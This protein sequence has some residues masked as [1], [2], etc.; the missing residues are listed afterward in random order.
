MVANA[1]DKTDLPSAVLGMTLSDITGI[2]QYQFVRCFPALQLDSDKVQIWLL[3][4]YTP[5][6]A[7]GAFHAVI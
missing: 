7:D 6:G 2:V 4:H 1:L 5:Y 3:L